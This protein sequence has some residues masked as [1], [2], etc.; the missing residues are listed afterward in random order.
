MKNFPSFSLWCLSWP[1]WPPPRPGSRVPWTR[2]WPRPGARTSWFW[3]ISTAV[4]E[5]AAY[6]WVSSI[7][8]IPSTRISSIQIWSSSGPTAQDK[9]GDELFQEI[10][11]PGH[12][13]HPVH[14]RQRRRSGLDPGVRSAGGQIPAQDGQGHRPGSTHSRPPTRPMSKSR[15]A[16]RRSSS[17][18]ASGTTATAE[19]KAKDFYRLVSLS[20]RRARPGPIGPRMRTSRSA[21]PNPPNSP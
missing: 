1:R 10:Q 16:S 8:A 17:W 20:T 11:N 15:G 19:D 21:T 4:A 18:P 3:S 12:S 7:T 9:L 13:D 6:C 5:G 2:P 14:R